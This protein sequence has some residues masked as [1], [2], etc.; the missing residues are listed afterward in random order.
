MAKEQNKERVVAFRL[1]ETEG[2]SLDSR[3]AQEKIVGVRSG[4]QLARKLVRD[5]L[6]GRLI[7]LNKS[8]VQMD[9]D[10]AMAGR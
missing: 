5:Y 8:D 7:Y 9:S 6:N 10:V 1:P 4:A 3:A 2:E